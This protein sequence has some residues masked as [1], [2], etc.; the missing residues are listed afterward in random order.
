ME[1]ETKKTKLKCV[2][3]QIVFK[4]RQSS[5]LPRERE[6]EGE[7]VKKLKVEGVNFFKRPVEV[8]SE[9]KSEEAIDHE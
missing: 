2:L 9:E 8:S 4:T 1:K 7:R 3:N 5:E 6:R